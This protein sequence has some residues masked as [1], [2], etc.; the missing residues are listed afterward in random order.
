MDAAASDGAVPPAGVE[1]GSAVSSVS[2]GSGGRPGGARSP[3][4]RG[5]IWT[6]AGTSTAKSWSN[7]R[8]K[9]VSGGV[10]VWRGGVGGGQSSVSTND[11]QEHRHRQHK[12]TPS[13]SQVFYQFDKDNSGDL[14]TF[15]M[16]AA[17]TELMGYPPSTGQVGSRR[18][19][20]E[21]NQRVASPP[22]QAARSGPTPLLPPPLPRFPPLPLP[23]LPSP[24]SPSP[25]LNSLVSS[26]SSLRPFVPSLSTLTFTPKVTAIVAGYDKEGSNTLTLDQ[27][28]SLFKVRN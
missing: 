19:W 25:L 2:T 13:I 21:V 24:S 1:N 18:A 10:G 6:A 12:P 8:I 28:T 27:F 3:A 26:P 20:P 9:E 23:P 15:E 22:A 14:D 5:S 17:I 4:R 7:A 11:T 16:S